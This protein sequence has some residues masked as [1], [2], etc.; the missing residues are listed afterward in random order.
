MSQFVGPNPS[1]L[2]SLPPSST[3]LTGIL[4]DILTRQ[5]VSA[6]YLSE[7]QLK[8][9]LWS[10]GENTDILIEASYRWRPET[11]EKRPAIIIHRNALQNERRGAGNVRQSGSMYGDERFTTF[12]TGSHTLFCIGGTGTQAEILADEVQ[13][14]LTEFSLPIAKAVR[15]IRFSVLQKGPVSLLEESKENLVVP[16]TVGYSYEES[17]IVRQ[18]APTLSNIPLT[19]ILDS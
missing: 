18:Q 15:L 2:C 17:W 5:F 3:L 16:V 4:R 13:R 11:T 10:S 12:W 19:K 9:L 6:N 1:S 8:Q 7:P 14:H